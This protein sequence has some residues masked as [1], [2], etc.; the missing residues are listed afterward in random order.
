MGEDDLP[1]ELPKTASGK[2]Q[3]HVLRS[4]APSL[5]EKEVGRVV[6]S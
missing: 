6:Q 1:S 2:I 4:W 5:V 3:K